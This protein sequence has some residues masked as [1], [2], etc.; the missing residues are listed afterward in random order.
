MMPMQPP[1]GGQPGGGFADL[2]RARMGGGA[3]TAPPSGIPGL[4]GAGGQ[5]LTPEL[6]MAFLQ[7]IMSKGGMPGGAPPPGVPAQMP[8]PNRPPGSM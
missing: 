6:L 7:F 1:Q 3:P 5:Q 2:L 8:M 4:P